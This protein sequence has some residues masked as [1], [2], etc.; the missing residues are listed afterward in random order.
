MIHSL[1]QTF[2]YANYTLRNSR[3][4]HIVK[5]KFNYL[6]KIHSVVLSNNIKNLKIVILINFQEIKW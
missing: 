5:L 1:T 2:H 6:S 4:L 3:F